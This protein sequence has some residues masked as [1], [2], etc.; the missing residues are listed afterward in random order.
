MSSKKTG[1][2]VRDLVIDDEFSTIG[3]DT[4]VVQAA[5]LMKEKTVP[6]LVVLDNTTKKVLGVVADFD[7]VHDIVATGKDPA[8]TN[9]KTAMYQIEPV[10]LDTPVEDA[11]LRMQNLKVTVVPV[12]EGGKLLGV[13]TIQD[14]WSYIPQEGTDR[15]GVIPVAN[16]RLAEMWLGCICAITAFIIGVLFPLAGIFGYFTADGSQLTELFRLVVMP[17]EP[18]TFYLFEAHGTQFFMNFSELA[19][20]AGATWVL[21]LIFSFALLITAIIGLFSIFY[22]SFAKLRNLSVGKYHQ[23]LFPLMVILF[24]GLEWVLFA[25][26]LGT[27][28]PPI[29]TLQIDGVGLTCSL[30][31]ITLILVATF[32]DFVFIQ[33]TGGK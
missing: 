19:T 23:R 32:R 33:K 10:T 15:V 3:S 8:A 7:I 25:I 13:C 2:K 14:C 11:F 27:N 29:T 17:K 30:V 20:K 28:T 16:S 6:D 18:I 21:L 9:V 12:V 4:T 24:I 1:Y 22:S 5:Q 26:V 31:A